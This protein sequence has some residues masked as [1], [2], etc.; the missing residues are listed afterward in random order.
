[1]RGT[2]QSNHGKRREDSRRL[3]RFFPQEVVDGADRALRK[4]R[5]V[6]TT[7]RNDGAVRNAHNVSDCDVASA[8]PS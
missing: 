6:P 7:P 1:L 2:L 3:C 4:G 5:T 8:P